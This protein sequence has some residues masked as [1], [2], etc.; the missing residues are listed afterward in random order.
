ME[1]LAKIVR[2]VPDFPKK[3][4]V[5]RDITTLLQDAQSYQR[6]IDLMAHRYIGR[7]IDLVLGVEARGFIIGS[8]L[9]YKLGTGVIIVRKPG[10]LPYRT[11]K[12]TYQL[13]YGEDTLEIHEDAI[14]PG[15]KVLIADDVLA[16]GG[17]VAACIDLVKALGGE[18]VECAFLM[19]LEGLKGRERLAPYEAFSLLKF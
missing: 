19:E 8:A 7:D 18:V 5:F 6:V 15:Q 1:Q 17:T 2:L 9:A 12:V 10:K 3:G 13:E 4:I 14:R 11:Q 16:T